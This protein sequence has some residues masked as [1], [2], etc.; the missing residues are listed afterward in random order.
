M[1]CRSLCNALWTSCSTQWAPRIL[2]GPWHLLEASNFAQPL[3]LDGSVA[4]PYAE[5]VWPKYSSCVWAKKHLN[6]LIRNLFSIPLLESGTPTS[7]VEHFLL[8][9]CCRYGYRPWILAHI[10]WVA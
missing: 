2:L 9:T 6:L 10:S 7:N 1:V 4:T 3:F 8:W 5:I